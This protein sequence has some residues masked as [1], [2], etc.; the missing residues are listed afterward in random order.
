MLFPLKFLPKESYHEAPR[1][2]GARRSKGKRK[3]AGCDLYAPIGTPVF[4]VADGI[5]LAAYEFYLSS[6]AV[7]VDHGDFVVRYGEVQRKLGPGIKKGAKIRAGDLIGAVGALKG[8]KLSM[9][10]FE[11]YSGKAKGPLTDKANAPYMR[12]W[13]LMDP[14]PWLDESCLHSGRLD[15]VSGL[16]KV[17]GRP[18]FLNHLIPAGA[19]K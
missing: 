1:C 4:A 14:T 2:F 18:G 12:R 16:M 15:D 9:L 11:M 10:H 3:H 19:L 6:W 13:D 5:V 17:I 7:E 8:L